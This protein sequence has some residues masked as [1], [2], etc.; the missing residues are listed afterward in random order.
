MPMIISSSLKLY[1]KIYYDTN[2]TQLRLAS[3]LRAVKARI[4]WI[5]FW[6]VDKGIVTA[7]EGQ[8]AYGGRS[9]GKP[10]LQYNN[11]SEYTPLYTPSN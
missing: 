10:T 11:Q 6:A 2:T 4:F 1:T 7:C 9:R 3:N 5:Y 8:I